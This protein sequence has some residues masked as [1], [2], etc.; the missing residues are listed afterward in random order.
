MRSD[1]IC[2]YV[3]INYKMKHLQQLCSPW[4]GQWHQQP[5]TFWLGLFVSPPQR[6]LQEGLFQQHLCQMGLLQ[7]GLLLLL[8]LLVPQDPLLLHLLRQRSILWA[9]LPATVVK[10]KKTWLK[11]VALFIKFDRSSGGVAYFA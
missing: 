3:L 1:A 7:L 6:L 5:Q 8:L 4:L 9:F 11:R 10:S 2:N